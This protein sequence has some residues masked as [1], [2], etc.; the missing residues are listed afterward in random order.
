MPLRFQHTFGKH[1]CISFPLNSAF[2]TLLLQNAQWQ[3]KQTPE[4]TEHPQC[5]WWLLKE[6]CGG[7]YGQCCEARKWTGEFN[8]TC[9]LIMRLKVQHKIILGC[10]SMHAFQ[11]SIPQW[12]QCHKLQ[13][14]PALHH[15]ATEVAVPMHT[16]TDGVWQIAAL[17]T[18]SVI[19]SHLLS[20]PFPAK[21]LDSTAPAWVSRWVE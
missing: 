17:L 5:E 12:V 14:K 4:D 15:T 9:S 6:M 16:K 2:L 21:P 3:W 8:G 11:G 20:S 1:F 13:S 7:E 18:P 19:K 10:H